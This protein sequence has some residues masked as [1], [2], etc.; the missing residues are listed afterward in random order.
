LGASSKNP[1]AA[2][3]PLSTA[4]RKISTGGTGDAG[5]MRSSSVGNVTS[6]SPGPAMLEQNSS[7]QQTIATTN[8]SN[9]NQ[10]NYRCYICAGMGTSKTLFVITR[11]ACQV[12]L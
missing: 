6:A 3:V 1:G 10:Q 2:V 4:K 9:S 5:S 8:S 7:G 12:F 11:Y